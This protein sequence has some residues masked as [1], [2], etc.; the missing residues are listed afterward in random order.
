MGGLKMALKSYKHILF[1]LDHTL[2][3]YE[4]NSREVLLELHE[5]YQLRDRTS[6]SPDDFILGFE[7][8][9]DKLW[10]MYNLGEIE[11]EVLR[12]IRFKNILQAMDVNQIPD[13]ELIEMGREYVSLCPWKKNLVPYAFEILHY[14]SRNYQLH[15]ITNGFD[16]QQF[17]KLS[18]AGLAPYFDQIVTSEKAGHKKPNLGI[19]EFTLNSI[20]ATYSD[21]IMI[22]DN[23]EAD[24]IGARN[25]NIDQIYFNPRGKQHQETITYEIG[26]LS[27][28]KEIL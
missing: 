27:E 19:F 12:K 14:L 1:D 26:C 3:D 25:A 5:K 22:G 16:Q 6:I 21:C 7:R 17:I 10:Q 2:W 28:I 11:G 20:T 23:L 13:S 9:N 4:L 18:N 15:V 8:E 24:I